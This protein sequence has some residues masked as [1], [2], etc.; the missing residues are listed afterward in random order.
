MTASQW[1]VLD[2]LLHGWPYW[3]NLDRN[4]AEQAYLWCINN[5]FVKDGQIT[6]TGKAALLI[7]NPKKMR[8]PS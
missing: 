6:E 3:I 5:E 7:N 4:F 1:L 8:E 2:N